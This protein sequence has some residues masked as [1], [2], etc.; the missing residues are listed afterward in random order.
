MAIVSLLLALAAEW[1]LPELEKLRRKDFYARY[2][3]FMEARFGERAFWDSPLGLLL[4]VGI[5]MILLIILQALLALFLFGL[6]ALLLA[7][8]I[9]FLS[10][11]P[12]NLFREVRDYLGRAEGDDTSAAL[13]LGAEITGSRS[14]D[15][16]EANA[17]VRDVVLC[18]ANDRLFGVIFWFMVL[19]PVGALLYR[20]AVE[21]H[22]MGNTRVDD[23]GAEPEDIASG[24]LGD[25]LQQ[26]SFAEAAERLHG[27]LAWVP[28]RLL[29][30]S[31][32]L[33]G[34]FEDTLV[35][36]RNEVREGGQSLLQSTR[37][38]LLAA[39]RGA[40]RLEPGQSGPRCGTECVRTG[41]LLVQ[42][43]LVV[44]LV[45]LALLTLAGWMV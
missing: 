31:Y 9:L 25:M 33:V 42:R 7:V 38:V 26:G 44:W 18:G 4:V 5:P 39:S 32:A 29:A 10:L 19:G 41:I 13:E 20:L 27:I 23:D 30:V 11:G 2:H 45:L 34:S 17:D 22:G 8:A 16:Q 43:S 37:A 12:G 14:D 1:F 36:W 6:P 3:T 40:L 21:A 15:V 28:A 35:A 24:T